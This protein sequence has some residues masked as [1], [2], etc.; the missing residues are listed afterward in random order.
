MRRPD[1]RTFLAYFLDDAP[2]NEPQQFMD[3]LTRGIGIA[4]RPPEFDSGSNQ[5]GERC[6]SWEFWNASPAQW[7]AIK[8][9]WDKLQTTFMATHHIRFASPLGPMPSRNDLEVVAG[10]ADKSRRHS[11]L[12][13]QRIR[14][15][16]KRG[17]SAFAS[18]RPQ[19]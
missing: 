17:K 5:Y 9:R 16:S 13:P 2:S 12:A 8:R 10:I 6:C 19:E 4:S 1:Q 15:K 18:K 11:P 3:E 14:G 7:S